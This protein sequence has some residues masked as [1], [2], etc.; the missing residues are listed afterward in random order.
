MSAHNRHTVREHNPN[1]KIRGR[2]AMIHPT[3]GYAVFDTNRPRPR[4]AR[5]R[6]A[7]GEPS[8]HDHDENGT[9]FENWDNGGESAAGYRFRDDERDMSGGYTGNGEERQFGTAQGGEINV[10]DDHQRERSRA[11]IG[12]VSGGMGMGITPDYNVYVSQQE[13]FMATTGQSYA[14]NGH[15][16]H[17]M[18]YRSQGQSFVPGLY[19]NQHQQQQPGYHPVL[20]PYPGEIS[21]ALFPVPKNTPM[22]SPMSI[23]QFP[24][25]SAVTSALGAINMPMPAIPGRIQ[26]LDSVTNGSLQGARDSNSARQ[27]LAV[28]REQNRLQHLDEEA[29]Q[30]KSGG[31]MTTGLQYVDD[32]EYAQKNAGMAN[33]MSMG[34]PQHYA[35]PTNN[36]FGDNDHRQQTSARHPLPSHVQ[37]SPSHKPAR[38]HHTKDSCKQQSSSSKHEGQKDQASKTTPKKQ[39]MFAVEDIIEFAKERFEQQ[40]EKMLKIGVSR[41]RANKYLTLVDFIEE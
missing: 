1:I 20:N 39:T 6:S 7:V 24:E 33:G 5:S 38:Q 3:H 22:F 17:Q 21:P 13:A 29:V 37:D 35:I 23:S 19:A 25:A 31:E 11:R 16:S 8:I 30:M 40:N 32:N 27:Q 28:S 34:S 2:K 26:S 15:A 14:L 4:D 10:N 12:A 18:G 36:P 9:G 41:Q